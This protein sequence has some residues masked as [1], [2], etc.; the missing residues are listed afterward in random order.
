[1]K[2][3]EKERYRHFKGEIVE[4]ICIALDTENLEKQVVYKALKDGRIWVRPYDMFTSKVDKIKYPDVEQ[5][6]RFQKIDND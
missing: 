2:V 1:M 4:I 6:Y 3:E 5:E